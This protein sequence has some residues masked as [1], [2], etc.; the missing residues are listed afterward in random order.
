M[1]A[2]ISGVLH[3]GPSPVWLPYPDDVNALMPSL[4]SAHTHR[5]PDG[6]LTVA[7]HRVTDLART[8][9]SPLYVLDVA[10]LQARA[11][12]FVD[13]F[14][15]SFDAVGT[16]ARVYYAGK[17]LL[18]AAIARWVADEGMG[19]DTCSLGELMTA[20]RAGVDPGVV[21]LH[22]NS[23]TDAEIAYA[24]DWGIARIVVDSLDEI[25]RVEAAAAA[26]GVRA[27][28]MIRVTVGVEAHTHDFIATAH[29]DQKFG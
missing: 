8:H 15:R 12:G 22:G 17:A 28:V 21:G 29:E 19:I 1:P 4:W 16:S 5:G 14:A 2:H 18:T 23:K 3:A 9:G 11:R 25:D 24:L 20:R 26:R 10:D 27:Q 13:A 7:G 6:V